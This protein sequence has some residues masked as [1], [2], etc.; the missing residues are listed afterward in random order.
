M[1]IWVTLGNEF[2]WS[3]SQ[4]RHLAEIQ[5]ICGFCGVVMLFQMQETLS[6]GKNGHKECAFLKM[7]ISKMRKKIKVSW[8]YS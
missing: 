1:D 6:L 3:V 5:P 4:N 8:T 7:S 2:C